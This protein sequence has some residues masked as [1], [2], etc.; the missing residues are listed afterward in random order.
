MRC[1]TSSI[2]DCLRKWPIHVQKSWEA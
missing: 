1:R 2:E